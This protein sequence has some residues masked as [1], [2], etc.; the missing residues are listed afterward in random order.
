MAF[1]PDDICFAIALNMR[2]QVVNPA[3]LSPLHGFRCVFIN[4]LLLHLPDLLRAMLVLQH[5]CVA[6]LSSLQND[7]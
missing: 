4:S 7:L 6:E 2:Q 3:G 5:Q 1:L